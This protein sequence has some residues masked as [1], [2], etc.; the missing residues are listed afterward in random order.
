MQNFY[1]LYFL[2]FL[3]MGQAQASTLYKCVDAKSAAISF[4][5]SACAPGSK[6][7]W[8]R[9]VVLASAPSVDELRRR[10]EIR[11]KN[12]GDARALSRRA[13]ID[14]TNNRSRN[15]QSSKGSNTKRTRCDAAKQKAKNTRD[16]D[17]NRMTV[18]KLRDLDASV[19]RACEPKFDF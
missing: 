13:G 8:A 16:R 6:Q 5:S 7:V 4:Q 11:E 14:S 12:S 17:W 10:D 18:K 19:Q 9:E 15:Y 3:T 2:C 1:R